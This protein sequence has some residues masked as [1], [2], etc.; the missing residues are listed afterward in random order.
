MTLFD[1]WAVPKGP[2]LDTCPGLITRLLDGAPE[3]FYVTN[4]REIL[5]VDMI[6]YDAL[7]R[8]RKELRTDSRY[9]ATQHGDMG[10]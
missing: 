8:W 2:S 9:R 5:K 10:S 3:F 7:C 6:V 1:S 4:D